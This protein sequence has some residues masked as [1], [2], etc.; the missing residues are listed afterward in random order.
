MIG[1]RP[2]QA[3]LGTGTTLL[4][5]VSAW[6]QP[7]AN[8]HGTHTQLGLAPCTFLGMT[9]LPCPMCGATTTFALW[10]DGRPLDGLIN[11]PFASLLFVGTAA[12]SAVAWSEA[13]APRGRWQKLGDA[14]AP[15]E[16]RLLSVFLGLMA[17]SWAY[18]LARWTPVSP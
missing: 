4:L 10:A 16:L 5:A 2:V 18:S 6:L 8:G 13:L 11:H 14:I 7:S 15:Y 1:S 17:A 12:V 3:L 9:G